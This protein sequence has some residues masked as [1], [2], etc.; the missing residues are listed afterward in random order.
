MSFFFFFF[1]FF[2]FFSR[3]ACLSLSFS[4]LEEKPLRFEF[5]DEYVELTELL[6]DT[7]DADEEIEA[8]D[9]AVC[10]KRDDEDESVE[11]D[12][13]LER[14]DELDGVDLSDE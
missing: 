3:L 4:C 7:D 8:D 14:L 6:R 11:R 5:E 12:G 13:L 10:D 1:F 2:N 9:E